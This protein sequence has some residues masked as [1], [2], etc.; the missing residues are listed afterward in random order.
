MRYL[1]EAAVDSGL[2]PSAYKRSEGAV[3]YE[4]MQCAGSADKR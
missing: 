1:T 4:F 2:K 3:I